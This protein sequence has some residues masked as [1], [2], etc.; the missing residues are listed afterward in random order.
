MFTDHLNVRRVA[1][2]TMM[3][4]ALASMADA[5]KCLIMRQETNDTQKD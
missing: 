5:D 2:F 4:A 3:A 1:T